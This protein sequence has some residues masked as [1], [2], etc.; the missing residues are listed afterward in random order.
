MRPVAML[1]MPDT[2]WSAECLCDEHS[3][4]PC[5]NGTEPIEMPFGGQTRLGQEPF[6]GWGAQ[7]R[8]LTNTNE[9]SV[10]GGDTALRQ[11]TSIT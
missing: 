6:I 10:Q 1:P 2:P 7:W 8:H 5:Q 3:G 11:S 9:R 4:K